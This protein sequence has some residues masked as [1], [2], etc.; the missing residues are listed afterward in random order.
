[1][2][3]MRAQ[4]NLRSGET[5]CVASALKDAQQAV[6]LAPNWAQGRRVLACAL[7]AGKRP[8]DAILALR[9][10]LRLAQ[11]Q[12]IPALKS[13]LR[14]LEQGSSN[15]EFVERVARDEPLWFE[16]FEDAE[17]AFDLE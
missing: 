9:D 4:E 11:G 14:R 12:D 1:M 17:E 5:D 8:N 6:E 7:E 2:G 15:A 3:A 13:Q 16:D 10:A